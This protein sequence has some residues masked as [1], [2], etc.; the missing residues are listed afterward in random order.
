MD[1]KGVGLGQT[2]YPINI[3]QLNNSIITN[4]IDN[5]KTDI[6]EVVSKFDEYT[7]TNE[8]VEKVDK[9]KVDELKSALDISEED[10]YELYK[11]G[12]NL[13]EL[14][15]GELLFRQNGDRLH[16]ADNFS[17]DRSGSIDADDGDSSRNIDNGDRLHDVDSKYKA[18]VSKATRDVEKTKESEKADLEKKLSAIKQESSNMYLNM[19]GTKETV[20]V[21][22]LYESTFKGNFR[23]NG[24]TYSDSELNSVLRMNGLSESSD[25]RWAANMLM[26]HDQ[27]VDKS[28]IN[29]LTQIK[30]VVAGL[31]SD[32]VDAETELIT[33]GKVNYDDDYIDRVTDDLGMVTEEH[34]QRL[35]DNKKEI[36]IRNLRES[37]KELENER[38]EENKAESIRENG[39][40]LSNIGTSTIQGGLQGGSLNQ[41]GV[42]IE[43]AEA[44]AIA[45]SGVSVISDE[46]IAIKR[47]ITQ[48]CSK[49]TTQAAQKISET[50]PLESS[51]LMEVANALNAMDREL[52]IMALKN[53]KV[54]VSE[55]NIETV[56]NVMDSVNIMKQNFT[57]TVSVQ[58]ATRENLSIG[59]VST[60]VAALTDTEQLG[61]EVRRALGEY[62]KNE[63][64]LDRSLGENIR[65]VEGQIS[66]LLSNH[67]I[68]VNDINLE[69]AKALIT[70]GIDVSQ[71]NIDLIRDT[72]LK[73]DAFLDEMTPNQIAN[74]LKEG[75]NVLDSSVDELLNATSTQQLSNLQ[76]SVAETILKLQKNNEITDT[77]R[78][79]LVG[80]YRILNA[81]DRNKEEVIGYLYRNELPITLNNL[82][83]AARYI[84]PNTGINTAIDDTTGELAESRVNPTLTTINETTAEAQRTLEILREAENMELPVDPTRRVRYGALLYPYLKEQFKAELG[85]F[86]G[87]STLPDSFLEKIEVAQN[88]DET[89]LEYMR[90]N[91]MP[92]TL[93]NMYWMDK[94]V[95]SPDTFSGIL[96]ENGLIRENLP[97]NLEEIEDRLKEIE[98]DVKTEKE[99]AMIDSRQEVYTRSKEIEDM[100]RFQRNRIENEGLYQIPFMM[101]GEM[102]MVNLYIKDENGA[103]GIDAT[104]NLKAVIKYQTQ[105]IGEVT[106][107]VEFKGENMG[108]RVQTERHADSDRITARKEILDTRLENIGYNVRHSEINNAASEITPSAN[109]T[110]SNPL[111]NF[112]SMI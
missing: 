108:Y 1:I 72:V 101:N 103:N 9:N 54:D 17:G 96:N 87:M 64:Q 94:I 111:S 22:S 93:S 53:A 34:I 37:V 68:E 27:E 29:S 16:K 46:A 51:N 4:N 47:Q 8:D 15:L 84:R 102:R 30:D 42:N 31:E 36:N 19:L 75:V 38:I 14:D 90:Q 41:D 74:L 91:E 60:R 26:T 104:G 49:L 82:Q 63:T 92:V 5:I 106:V 32:R 81:V 110:I 25:N 69:A 45:M 61:L 28:K 85:R 40:V 55:E 76:N 57:N 58:L 11:N 13:D 39:T 24:N 73:V 79:G 78:D 43:D 6:K 71:Q 99:N 70:N 7:Y 20:T 65:R 44:A 67:G 100:I 10:I 66:N 105:N 88:L 56:T 77:Q 48:I 97:R 112:E 12:V 109:V 33:G 18:I 98:N 95:K 50:M 86:E 83:R 52:A 89:V 80:I 107:H 35:I 2:Q 23:E 59:A 62:D 21:N 3:K